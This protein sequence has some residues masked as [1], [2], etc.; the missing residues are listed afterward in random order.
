MALT[1]ES[2]TIRPPKSSSDVVYSGRKR[3]RAPL[4]RLQGFDAHGQKR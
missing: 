2:M 3:L 4:Y 1:L